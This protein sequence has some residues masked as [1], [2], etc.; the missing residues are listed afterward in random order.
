MKIIREES[1]SES[2]HQAV[3]RITEVLR[4]SDPHKPLVVGLC[5]GRSVGAILDALAQELRQA[6]QQ[7]RDRLHFFVIDERMVPLTSEDSNYALLNDRFFRAMV[8]EGVLHSSQ[9]HPFN[10]DTAHPEER[11]AEYL[12]ELQ[13]CGGELTVVVLGMGE[14]AHVAGAFP[15]HRV[16]S[17]QSKGFVTFSDS[18]KPPSGRMT[19]TLPLLRTAKLG[20]LLAIG[21]G[22]RAAFNAFKDPT[23]ALEA[24]PAKVCTMMHE[25]IVVTDL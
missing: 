14:D 3:G 6:D 11:C 5:G 9:I 15:H 18:P 24:C 2:S 22:K 16:L 19:A 23:V 8:A 1:L 10:P 25:A 20:V 12:A 4:A 21:E 13:E 7:L 17:I